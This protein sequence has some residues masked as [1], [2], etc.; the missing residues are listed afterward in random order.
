VIL[1]LMGLGIGTVV[2]EMA[3]MSYFVFL[4]PGLL[5]SYVMFAP[6]FESTWNTYIRMTVRRLYDAIIVTPLTIEDVVTGEILWGATRGVM[7]AVVIMVVLV[8]F[9]L[10]RSPMAVLVFPVAALEAFM[11]AAMSMCYV[12]IAPSTNSL[13]FYFSLIIYPMFFMSGVFFPV[14]DLP[15]G[16]R[17]VAWLLPLTHAVHLTRGL[18]TGRF[19]GSM[20]ASLLLIA[21]LGAGFYVLA[22]RLMRRRLIK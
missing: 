18:A 17:P 10:V 16:V 14:E 11:V 4:G 7:M 1:A 5:A 9:G 20:A 13:N 2:G 19:D 8:A 6:A 12:A 15:P 22:L 3:G 21:V